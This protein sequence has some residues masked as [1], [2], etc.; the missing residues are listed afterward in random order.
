M[1]AS[2]L[3]A[4]LVDVLPRLGELQ[5][6]TWCAGWLPDEPGVI[7]MSETQHLNNQVG[8]GALPDAAAHQACIAHRFRLG[9]T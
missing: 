9:S 6:P 3:H 4:F 1:V 8:I 5:I 2:K 7:C